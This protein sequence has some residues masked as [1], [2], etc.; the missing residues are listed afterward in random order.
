MAAIDMIKVLAVIL[1]FIYYNASGA[2]QKIPELAK[3]LGATTLLSYLKT[4]GL[5]TELEGDGPFTLF[6]PTNEA[7]DSLPTAVKEKL[8]TDKTLLRTV[9][10]FHV[11]NGAVY[12]SQLQNEMLV[13]SLD[14]TL[15]IRINIYKGGQVITA[16]GSQVINP[17]QNATNGVIHIVDK[18]LYPLPNI[19]IPQYVTIS[20][21]LSTLFYCVVQG[22]LTD[23][24]SGQG[25][26]TLFAPDNTAFD[27][28][29]PGELS[30]LLSNQTAL[31][32]VLKYHV[33]S[34]TQY[35]KGL[36]DGDVSTLEGKPVKIT[37]EEE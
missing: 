30:D 28:L 14:T 15:D 10:M 23:V 33:V 37:V 6:A 25:P 9:L 24:L 31:V 32:D 35:S 12:S 20:P 26:F 13:K 21:E 19:N 36:V 3:K 11:T 7:F 16:D 18:V 1:A 22:Q 2:Q 27:N 34:G 8:A 17:N 29:P 5:D 4:A